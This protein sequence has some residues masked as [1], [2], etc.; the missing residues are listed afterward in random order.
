MNVLAVHVHV[1]NGPFHLLPYLS[2]IC[3]G[4]KLV[5]KKCYCLWWY[6]FQLIDV[7]ILVWDP[8]R[9]YMHCTCGLTINLFLGD[10]CALVN[11]PPN[12]WKWWLHEVSIASLT[13][14]YRW[15][16]TSCSSCLVFVHCIVTILA[17][18]PC[19]SDHVTHRR[20]EIHL[21]YPVSEFGHI[22][23]QMPC[24]FHRPDSHL[25]TGGLYLSSCFS[26]CH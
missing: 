25:S 23:L 1:C 11:I 2:H 20:I 6:S 4:I 22:L 9:T 3:Q 18:P 15:C 19:H 8:G 16:S 24:H 21:C 5:H 17:L 14:R 12:G 10:Y 26:R 13:T 7:V